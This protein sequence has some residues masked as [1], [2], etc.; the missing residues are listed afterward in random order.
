MD[1]LTY[2]GLSDNP[3]DQ[4]ST[5]LIETMDYQEMTHRLDYLKQ[6]RG[7]GIFS[8]RPG[9]GKT[10]ILR[11][12]LMSLTSHRYRV[13]ELPITTISANEFYKLFAE[14]LGLEAS[15]RKSLNFKAIQARL[16]E[17]YEIE[18][19]LP[20]IVIDEAQHLQGAVFN[21]LVLLMNFEMDSVKRCVLILSGVSQ[22]VQLLNRAQYEAF[23]QRVVTHYEVIGLEA[24]EVNEY[25]TQKLRAAGAKEPLFHDS[26]LQDIAKH[27]GSSL[28]QI[29]KLVTHCLRIGAIKNQRQIDSETVYAAAQE[30]LLA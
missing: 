9:V 15:G 11:H 18:R 20:I 17:L 26:V 28:R 4:E 30:I 24:N 29:D 22:M 13:I 7:I 19:T 1:F 6:T 27:S 23:R 10:T 25:V 8:G 5:L 14:A 21:E 16:S 2:Y 3:F 12:Y